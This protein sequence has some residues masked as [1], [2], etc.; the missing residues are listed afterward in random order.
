MNVLFVTH[1]YLHG[2]GG[3]VFASRAYINAFAEIADHVTLLY[4]YK[5][6]MEIEKISPKVEAIPVR[7][8]RSNIRKLFS[9]ICG[10]LHRYYDIFE[11]VLVNG[12]YDLV[13]FDNS[14]VSFGLIDI[15][16]HYNKRVITIHHN[17]ELE[18]VRDNSRG[19]LGIVNLYWTKRQEKDAVLKSDL[20][21]T[22]TRQD[23]D[24]F[25]RL[26]LNGQTDRMRYL[27]CFEYEQSMVMPLKNPACAE[28]K[29]FVITGN[30]SATQTEKAL[31]EWLDTCYPVM[32][33]IIPEFRLVIAGKN[34][35]ERLRRACA[36]KRIELIPSPVSMI[37]ILEGADIYICPINL[38]GGLKLRVMDGLKYG[39]P[40]IAHKISARG[41]DEF[42]QSGVVR[43]Y[44]SPA[45]FAECLGNTVNS[46]V[47][48][49]AVQVEY[50]R[51]FFFEAGV[52]RLKRIMC[53]FMMNGGITGA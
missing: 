35:G 44:D 22:I 49:D 8:N 40:V 20:N 3:G 46:N 39:L 11:Q 38:G 26:Y 42:V 5:E 30:L 43:V 7:D 27:G 25:A 14:R 29:R 52:E 6:G 9:F 10:K 23:L 36:A 24:T 17:C 34:P 28:K 12:N 37:P 45:S 21:L 4:P 15:A 31:L 33:N 19:L 32:C 2:N 1:H 48:K 47:A 18:Y 13:V 50:Q 16:H 53:P 51:L 41:Y